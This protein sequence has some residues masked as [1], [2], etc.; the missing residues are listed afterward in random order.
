LD[1]IKSSGLRDQ[2]T[3]ARAADP[4]ETRDTILRL[5]SSVPDVHWMGSPMGSKPM[6][7]GMLLAASEVQL[8]IL[9]A[10]PRSYHPDYSSGSGLQHVYP[11]KV[12]GIKAYDDKANAPS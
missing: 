6:A 4:F 11:L 2:F 12:D 10:R 5:V 3:Y 8:T 7:L 1:S 9:I